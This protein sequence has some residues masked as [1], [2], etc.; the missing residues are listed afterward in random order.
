MNKVKAVCDQRP[1]GYLS[2]LFQSKV[3]ELVMQTSH[4]LNADQE[5]ISP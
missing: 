3:Q 2:Q 1:A 4:K 5:C